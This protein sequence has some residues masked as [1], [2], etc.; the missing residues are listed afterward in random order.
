[1]R[2]NFKGEN[3]L[4]ALKKGFFLFLTLLFSLLIFSILGETILRVFSI[5]GVQ[6]NVSKYDPLVGGGLY[7]HSTNIYRNDRGDFAERGINQW[8]YL[9]IKHRKEKTKHTYRIGFFGDSYTQASQVPIEQTFFRL[10]ENNLNTDQNY[11]VECLAFGINGFSTF[12]S[13]LNSERWV[14]FF[15]LDMIIYVFC[16]NDIGDQIKSIKGED[17]IPYPLLIQDGFI[18]DTTFYHIGKSKES[19]HFKLVDYMTSHSLL[20]ATIIGRLK[21]L[22]KY[23]IKTEMEESAR[24]M[25]GSKNSSLI[26]KIPNQNDLPSLWPDSLKNHALNVESVVIRT[27]RDSIIKRNKVFAITYVPREKEI[28]KDSSDQDTWKS[29]LESFCAEQDIIFIDPTQELLDMFGRGNEIYYDHFTKYGHIAFGDAFIKWFKNNYS[30]RLNFI[31][32]K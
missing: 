1:M 29:W 25:S 32:E 23:G 31:E 8:G 3:K 11:N 16:E 7:P 18:I 6:F 9:D 22:F 2:N 14:D 21:L 20:A 12:Q 27:W 28:S 10:I 15:N 19:F 17:G 5:P 4:S 24:M 30:P 13:Y 26:N